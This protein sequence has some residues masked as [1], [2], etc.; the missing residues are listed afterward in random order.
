[1]YYREDGRIQLKKAI[2]AGLIILFAGL[3]LTFSFGT[4]QQQR[5]LKQE[6]AHVNDRWIISGTFKKGENLTLGFSIQPDW[7][8]PTYYG[9]DEDP[10][11]Y[12]KYFMVNVTDTNTGNFTLFNVILM[13]PLGE[14][15]PSYPYNFLLGIA[16]IK[17]DHHGALIADDFPRYRIEGIVNNAGEYVVKCWLDPEY[18]LLT[19]APAS[20]PK[21][22]YL[23]AVSVE[24]TYPYSFLLPLGISTVAIGMVATVWGVKGQKRKARHKIIQSN[25]KV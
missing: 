10:P 24:T 1:V 21:D 8:M 5:T 3:I 13:P 14:T 17:V 19:R 20:P 25:K 11:V 9:F 6:V 2:A 4:I 16:L 15:P 18:V 22:L 12:K 7:S 23:Y